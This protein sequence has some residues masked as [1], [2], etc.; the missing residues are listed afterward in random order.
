MTLIAAGGRFGGVT[1]VHVLPPSRVTC[2]QPVLVPTQ[3]TPALTGE[4]ASAWID[5][6]ARGG[7]RA[8]PVGA[9][10]G[11]AG[12]APRAREVGA[13]RVPRLAAVARRQH[14]LRAPCRA[15]ADPAARTRAAARRRSDR[16]VG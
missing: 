1:F 11:C 2:T 9:A 14:V 16:R 8:L 5:P 10:A 15:C 7:P 4:G 12:G 6:P 3:I 13:D